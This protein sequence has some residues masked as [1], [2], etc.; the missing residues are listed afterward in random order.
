[1]A[2]Q[3]SV[4]RPTTH[5]VEQLAHNQHGT[6]TSRRQSRWRGMDPSRLTVNDAT[7]NIISLSRVASATVHVWSKTTNRWSASR[8]QMSM[9]G[10]VDDG[11]SREADRRTRGGA[12]LGWAPEGE[13]HSN[14]AEGAQW[15]WMQG[16]ARRAGGRSAVRMPASSK[17]CPWNEL[18]LVAQGRPASI[19]HGAGRRDGD[20]HGWR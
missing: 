17:P 11:R 10:D 1:M 18:R 16:E 6:G 12:W 15:P 13:N 5:L 8:N 7:T 3:S 19:K 2:I 4:R 9:V 14:G 20:I